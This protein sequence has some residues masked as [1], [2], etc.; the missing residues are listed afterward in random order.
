MTRGC[1]ALLDLLEI[2]GNGTGNARKKQKGPKVR[3]PDQHS[4]I[5]IQAP[6]SPMHGIFTIHPPPIPGRVRRSMQVC[7]PGIFDKDGGLLAFPFEW[8]RQGTKMLGFAWFA[9][10]F[11]EGTSEGKV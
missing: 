2:P 7:E 8:H 6:D 10:R 3:G 11:L 9:G 1:M 4:R 5:A